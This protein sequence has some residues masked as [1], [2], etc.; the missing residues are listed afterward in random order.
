MVIPFPQ[1]YSSNNLKTE[2]QKPK[3]S[4][5]GLPFGNVIGFHWVCK[6]HCD[7]DKGIFAWIS[8]SQPSLQMGEIHH[9]AE[10]GGILSNRNRI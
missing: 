1:A 2:Y 10:I 7:F 4:P 9:K 3:G 6:L 8:P 5:F